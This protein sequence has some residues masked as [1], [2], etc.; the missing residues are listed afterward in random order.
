MKK[1]VERVQRENETLKKSSASAALQQEN[2]RL[3]NE[4]ENLRSRSEAEL[5]SRLESKTK[6]F[7]KI[8]MENERLRKALKRE[9]ESTQRLRVSKTSLEVTNEMLEAELDATNQRLREALSRPG[10]EV[11]DRKTGRAS[12]VTR[13]FE[14]KI[15]ELEKELARKTSSVSELKRRLK[16]TSQREEEA[17][18]TIRQLQDQV[19]MLRRFPSSAQT[20]GPSEDFQAMR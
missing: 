14:N 7:E 15:N 6:E 12:V 18:V 9:V 19:H 17:Q 3:K 16:E 2:L 4:I 13:M 11:A 20:E 10:G 8:V 5:N 1:V